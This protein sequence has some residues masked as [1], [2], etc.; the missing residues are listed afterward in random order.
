LGEQAKSLA[1]LDWKLETGNWKLRKSRGVSLVELVVFIVIVSVAIAGIIGVISVTTQSSA[2]PLIRKQAL[3]IAEAFLEEVQLQPFTY[4]D[5]DDPTAATATLS[6][7]GAVAIG[8]IASASFGGSSGNTYV[9]VTGVNLSGQNAVVVFVGYNNVSDQ[10]VTSVVIDPGGANITIPNLADSNNTQSGGDDAHIYI[11][12][13]VNPPQGTYTVR[14]NFNATL[15]SGTGINVVVYPLSGVDTT[16]PFRTAGTA[17]N[18]SSTSSVTV[19]SAAGDLVLA[20]VTGETINTPTLTSAGVADRNIYAGSCSGT[21]CNN[22]TATAHRDG[23]A[24]SV[25]FSWTHDNDHWAAVGVSVKPGAGCPVLT[26]AIGPE[27]YLGFT[28]TRYGLVYPFDNVNDYHGFDSNTAVPSGIT[29]IDGTLIAG[30]EGY[31]VTV[32][33]A[34]QPPLGGIDNVTNGIQSLLI[35]VTVTGPGNTTVTLN[36][37]RTRYAPNAL[38]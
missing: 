21:D 27:T 11:H 23:A 2:D 15:S 33:V 9:N 35:T 16:T 4:C 13:L 22:N 18:D 14:V 8:T 17:E 26:E 10:T 19:P 31:R 3:A 28:E 24:T 5:P 7:G 29:T 12:G 38:P 1:P 32:S 6:G 36:G 37:Y 20:G 25:N 30:L 34:A